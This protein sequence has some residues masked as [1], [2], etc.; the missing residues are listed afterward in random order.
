M[1]FSTIPTNVL[2]KYLEEYQT[3][4]LIPISR[5]ISSNPPVTACNQTIFPLHQENEILSITHQCKLDNSVI[6]GMDKG[7]VIHLLPSHYC[8]KQRII[9]SNKI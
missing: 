9:S 6:V 4:D 1:R 2:W 7:F 5:T 8:I 3:F